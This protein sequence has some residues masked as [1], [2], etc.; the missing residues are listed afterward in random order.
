MLCHVSQTGGQSKET[1][2]TEGRGRGA[3]A[4]VKANK[5]EAKPSQNGQ[6]SSLS[7]SSSSCDITHENLLHHIVMHTCVKKFEFWFWPNDFNSDMYVQID[8]NPD[9]TQ[10]CPFPAAFSEAEVDLNQEGLKPDMHDVRITEKDPPNR[11]KC[12]A[13]MLVYKRKYAK[14]GAKRQCPHSRTWWAT[15]SRSGPPKKSISDTFD[16]LS[17][18]LFVVLADAIQHLYPNVNAA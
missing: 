13:V 17:A 3:R 7:S 5:G 15:C 2:E 18:W 14:T 11:T 8:K 16:L 1:E 10:W 9:R 6:Y 4:K 12:K